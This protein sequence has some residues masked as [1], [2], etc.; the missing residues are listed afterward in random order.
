M[1][2]FADH[3][4]QERLSQFG[5]QLIQRRLD[6]VS[7]FIPE[8]IVSGN[9]YLQRALLGQSCRGS[10]LSPTINHTATEDRDQP[11]PIAP[12]GV[13][14][15]TTFPHGT[16]SLLNHVLRFVLISNHTI[17]H[18]IQGCPVR[19]NQ[20][21]EAHRVQAQRLALVKLC[22]CRV[23]RHVS[24]FLSHCGLAFIPENYFDRKVFYGTPQR[25]PSFQDA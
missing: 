6:I 22:L 19:L 15:G 1:R 20:T 17:G 12:T 23:S 13:I 25:G 24:S 18:A 4:Q 2:Q 16:E 14:P 8:R 9:T 10:P 7:K 11:S 3:H 5:R 21:I